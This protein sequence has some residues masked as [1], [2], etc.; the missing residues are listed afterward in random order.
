MSV[1]LP[2]DYAADHALPVLYL[3][4]GQM[5]EGYAPLVEARILDGSL[6]PLLLVGVHAFGKPELLRHT[7]GN[8]PLNRKRGPLIGQ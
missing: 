1:Y 7:T 5:M 4:D 2:P 8:F 3:V 6:P